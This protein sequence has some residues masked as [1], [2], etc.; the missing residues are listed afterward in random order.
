MFTLSDIRK[1]VKNVLH[2]TNN[3][4]AEKLLHYLAPSYKG[5]LKTEDEEMSLNRKEYKDY[6]E[7]GWSGYGFYRARHEGENI[8][9]SPDK[10]NAILETDVIEIASLTNGATIK[11]RSHQKWMFENKHL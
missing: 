11:L 3:R 2:S 6:L 1:I 7:G 8:N 10:Q 9:I 5:T 4:E